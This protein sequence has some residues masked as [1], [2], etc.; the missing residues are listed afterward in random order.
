MENIQCIFCKKSTD[1]VAIEEDGYKGKKCP[2]CGLIYV[3]PR[4]TRS[5]IHALYRSSSSK[6][7]FAKCQDVFGTLST[8]LV[9]RHHVRIIK[10]FLQKG[11]IL[12]LGSG[13]GEFLGEARREGFDVSGIELNPRLSR[14]INEELSIPCENRPLNS[15]SFDSKKFDMVYLCDVLSHYHDPLSEF[16]QINAKLRDGGF[17]V[18]ETGNGG[19]ID[20]RY[21]RWFMSFQYPD[22]LFSFS[23]N[24]LLDLLSRTG[25]QPLRVYSFCILP[26][27]ILW[28]ALNY[29]M[30]S[31]AIRR[32]KGGGNALSARVVPQNALKRIGTLGCVRYLVRYKLGSLL[33]GMS[34]MPQTVIVVGRKRGSGDRSIGL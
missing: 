19:D 31:R 12:E 5:E 33:H 6:T 1:I 32:A 28:R 4:P 30:R 10:T 34:K 27:L 8:R 18:F 11:S 17:V 16:R 2:E 25:F 14:F 9:A 15:S 26:E 21:F 20:P 22:H 3:S 7:Y 24:N 29:L 23:V 13:T